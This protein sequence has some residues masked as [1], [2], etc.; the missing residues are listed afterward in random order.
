MDYDVSS[1]PWFVQ[2]PIVVVTT[3]LNKRLKVLKVAKGQAKV[4]TTV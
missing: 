1:W 2:K 4:E 3:S